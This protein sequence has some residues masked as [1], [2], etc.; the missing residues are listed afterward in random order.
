MRLLHRLRLRLA[1]LT[2]GPIVIT[3]GG[4]PEPSGRHLAAIGL[5]DT[6]IDTNRAWNDQHSQV[7][8]AALLEVRAEL[9]PPGAGSTVLRPAPG[10]ERGQ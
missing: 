3:G 4:P 1:L 8:V 6:L 9:C 10:R 7:V 2:R 5:I